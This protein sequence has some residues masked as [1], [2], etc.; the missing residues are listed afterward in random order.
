MENKLINAIVEMQEEEAVDL[1]RE[2]LDGGA[3]PL[4]V[5]NDC[6]SA[7]EIVG[8]KFE[9]GEY[10]IPQLMMAGEILTQISE[11]AKGKMAGDST[12]ETT[13]LG[14]VVLG[15]IE[16]DIHDIGKNIVTFILDINGFEVI[17]LGVNVSPAKFVE[18]VKEHQPQ[19]MGMSCLLTVA[20]DPM[21]QAVEALKEAGLR[22]RVKV[23]IGGAAINEQVKNYTGADA[24]G[25]DAVEAVN[26][27]KNWAEVH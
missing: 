14:K 11:L 3:K 27:A 1:A 8:K 18:A 9:E 4:D 12:Q 6:R 2:L 17:D 22:D 21:K 20:F 19:V 7:M 16:G 5:M 10:F 26:L 15:T 25:K 24:W 23:M 13:Y